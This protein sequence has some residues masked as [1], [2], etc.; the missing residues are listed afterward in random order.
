MKDMVGNMSDGLVDF[1]V[2]GKASFSD[3]TRSILIDIAKVAA[4]KMFTSFA[5]SLFADGGYFLVAK[6]CA[7]LRGSFYFSF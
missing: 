5:A 4:K 3:F 1:V 7:L 6:V 2:N